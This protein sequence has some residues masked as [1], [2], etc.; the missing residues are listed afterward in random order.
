MGM[1]DYIKF[2]QPLF[3]DPSGVDFQTK[4]FDCLMDQYVVSVKG[5]LYLECWDTEL[6]KAPDSFAG[7]YI[8]NIPGSYRREYLTTYTGIIT[9]YNTHTDEYVAKFIDGKLRSIT[10]KSRGRMNDTVLQQHTAIR[11]PNPR[12]GSEEREATAS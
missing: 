1:F 5:E 11:K 12:S 2:E 8:K 6:V 9:L 4:D 10:F 3:N 7:F